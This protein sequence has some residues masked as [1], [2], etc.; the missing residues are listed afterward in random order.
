MSQISNKKFKV[1]KQDNC[2]QGFYRLD[3]LQIQHEL[4]SGGTSALLERELFIRPDAVA[5]L[6]FD[7][8]LDNVILL[9]QF[10]VGAIDKA[11]SPWLL[12]IVAGLVEQNENLESVA[13][14]EALEEANLNLNALLPIT[15]YYPSPGGSNER[16]HLFLGKCDSSNAGGIFGLASENEDILL[17]VMPRLKAW[18]LLNQGKLDNAATLIALQ[19][20][21]LNLTKVQKLWA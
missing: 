11:S 12:E 10:R 16:V 3:K 9:E 19:W 18:Q 15:S 21:E 20:L 13:R 6:P 4:F 7:P 2:F 5:V 1:L 17:H 8:K 14:R